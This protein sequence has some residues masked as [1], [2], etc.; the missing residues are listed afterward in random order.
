MSAKRLL[1]QS[2]AQNAPAL[3]V[4]QLRHVYPVPRKARRSGV[5]AMAA[6][7]G[8]SFEIRPGEIFGVL[9]PNGGGKTTL[10]RIICTLLR[11][12]EGRLAV[13][14]HDVAEEAAQVRARL[15]VVFQS[16]SLDL[17]LTARENLRHQGNLYGLGGS[18]LEQRIDRW[19]VHFGLGDRCDE[20]AERFSGGLRRRLDVAKALL[21]QPQLLLLDEP[22]TALDVAARRDLWRQLV[23]LRDEYQV[24]VALTT[25]LMEIA[26]RCDRL[27]I[28]SAGR[29]VALESPAQL[30]ARIGGDVVTVKPAE[31]PQAICRLIKQR[32]GPW[33]DATEPQVVDGAIRLEKPDGSRFLAE[34]SV[35]LGDQI[36]SITVGRPTLEDVFLH[37]TG[38]KLD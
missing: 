13:F 28:L 2:A 11:P 14:G 35:A 5:D 20:L 4:D 9:G 23:R 12:T 7:D 22:A 32:F 29:L 18:D 34:L 27:A 38:S 26:D 30:K 15:G 3:R 6:I 31:D 33:P 10:F 1:D 21:H 8:V 25:H 17:K 36:E 24:T 16:P 19:L 37:L